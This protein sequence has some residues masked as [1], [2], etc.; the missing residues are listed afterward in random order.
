[1][2]RKPRR[3][4]KRAKSIL[5]LP[6]LEAAKSAVINSLSCPDAHRGYRHGGADREEPLCRRAGLAPASAGPLVANWSK[7]SS[8]WVISRFKPPNATSAA[9]NEL[10]Q[11]STTKS[12]SSPHYQARWTFGRVGD[13]PFGVS[14]LIGEIA[15]AVRP[16]IFGPRIPHNNSVWIKLDSLPYLSR[17]LLA[18]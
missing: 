15:H 12:E 10:R 5:R 17:D 6:D 11:P 18:A 2:T 4:E 3:K 1:M 13:D 7:F 16:K 8:S 9:H 14:Q